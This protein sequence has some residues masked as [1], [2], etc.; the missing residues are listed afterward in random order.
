M[1]RYLARALPVCFVALLSGCAPGKSDIEKSIKDEMKSSLGVEVVSVNLT[2]QS[3]G[4]YTGTATAVNGDVYDV[5]CDPPKGGK[6]E[7]RAFPS[8]AMLERDMRKDLEEKAKGKVKSLT[9]TKQ[10]PGTFT[11]TAVFEDGSK[12][13]VSTTVEGKQVMSKYEPIP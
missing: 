12:A 13:K 3:D 11:G 9:L 5:A 1:S 7:W 2:K 6:A 4:S 8:Q 10:G